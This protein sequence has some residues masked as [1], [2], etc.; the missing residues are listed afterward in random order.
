MKRG[1][2]QLNFTLNQPVPGLGVHS[3]TTLGVRR[4]THRFLTQ[5]NSLVNQRMG[6]PRSPVHSLHPHSIQASKTKRRESP[7]LALQ[8]HS[9]LSQARH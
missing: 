6:A 1:L 9:P 5:R 8:T 3:V 7:S 4:D 2:N